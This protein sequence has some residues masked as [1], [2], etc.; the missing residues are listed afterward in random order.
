[1]CAII[2]VAPVLPASHPRRGPLNNAS[3]SSIRLLGLRS[4]TYD[5]S[6]SLFLASDH[7][8]RP[9]PPG[10]PGFNGGT[11]GAYYYRSFDLG[12]RLRRWGKRG[13]GRATTCLLKRSEDTCYFEGVQR[14]I[15]NVR[16]YKLWKSL[17]TRNPS[18]LPVYMSFL[19]EEETLS[20]AYK[21]I[22]IRSYVDATKAIVH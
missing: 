9:T 4:S 19:S 3:H 21:D 16:P 17:W 18:K 5:H 6:G 10:P 15:G 8:I 11:A 20:F 7:L 22:S 1:M 2:Y 14:A 13:N 12:G